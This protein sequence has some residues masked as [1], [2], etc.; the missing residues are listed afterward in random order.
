MEI[1]AD[2]IISPAWDS[3]LEPVIKDCNSG[4]DDGGDRLFR[5]TVLTWPRGVEYVVASASIIAGRLFYTAIALCALSINLGVWAWRTI[6][7]TPAWER[8]Y[9]HFIDPISYVACAILCLCTMPF[10]YLPKVNYNKNDTGY[11]WNVELALKEIESKGREAAEEALENGLQFGSSYFL[12]ILF[13]PK[14]NS[15]LL[16]LFALKNEDLEMLQTFLEADE[17]DISLEDKQNLITHILK[18][19]ISKLLFLEPLFKQGLINMNFH[20]QYFNSPLGSIVQQTLVSRD[21]LE[22]LL[23]YGTSPNF[24]DQNDDSPLVKALLHNHYLYNDKSGKECQVFNIERVVQ[25]LLHSGA[26]LNNIQF[27][28]LSSVIGLVDAHQKEEAINMAMNLQEKNLFLKAVF[29]MYEEDLMRRGLGGKYHS[30]PRHNVFTFDKT[31]ELCRSILS[32]RKQLLDAKQ[33]A[34]AR[35]AKRLEFW[36]NKAAD[37]KEPLGTLSGQ[38]NVSFLIASFLH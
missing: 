16:L 11:P 31:I 35:V 17:E 14:K 8:G 2:F 33:P 34:I 15:L 19:D 32:F 24:L 6:C 13:G 20:L 1:T 25:P 21:L 5:V 36:L 28:E 10:G 29:E 23:K 18:K 22:M 3:C 26:K 27:D 30:W 37:E 38:K 4:F 9:F 7:F 12:P